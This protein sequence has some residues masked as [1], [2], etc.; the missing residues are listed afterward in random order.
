MATSGTAE[1]TTCPAGKSRAR[2]FVNGYRYIIK[3]RYSDNQ[4]VILK[5]IGISKGAIDV[6]SR[7][8][9]LFIRPYG[10]G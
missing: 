2:Y 5:M 3:N 9:G 8:F 1:Q 4:S 10:F 6:R 7:V